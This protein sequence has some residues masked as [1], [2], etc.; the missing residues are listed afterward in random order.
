[1]VGLLA[2]MPL[3][4]G[5][6]SG[7]GGQPPQDAAAVPLPPQQPAQASIPLTPVAPPS[8]ATPITA[9]FTPLPTP[10]QVKQAVPQG[11]LDPF[12]PLAVATSARSGQ[13]QR[14]RPGSTP[15]ALP[16]G[17]Q[18]TGVMSGGGRPVALVQFG[19]QSGSLAVGDAGGR[20]TDL[21][22]GNWW[23]A[24]IDVQRGRL[25]LVS[26]VP[27]EPRGRAITAEL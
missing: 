5:A 9:G 10:Q 2:L 4:L 3:L 20:T 25:T 16:E 22:P 19:S 15:L 17:F 1:M 13:G 12:A 7:C 6:L 11:R 27:G 26:R 8:A 18:F 23:V 24:A 14:V 21:L